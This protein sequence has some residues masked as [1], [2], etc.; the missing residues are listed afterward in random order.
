MI[1][2][3]TATPSEASR[4]NRREANLNAVRFLQHQAEIS[5][6]PAHLCVC[7]N[8]CEVIIRPGGYHRCQSCANHLVNLWNETR[9]NLDGAE[10]DI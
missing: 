6:T 1:K 4:L 9:A 2:G 10:G 5:I 8:P 3:T 7:G